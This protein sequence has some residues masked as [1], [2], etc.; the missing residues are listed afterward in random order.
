MI[1]AYILINTTH[2]R[3]RIV[4]KKLSQIE[5]IQEVEEVYGEYD[6]IA[7]I[8]VNNLD[9]LREVIYNKIRVI[10]GILR[11]ETLI[12]TSAS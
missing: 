5:G 4:S 8:V 12:S 2:D 6:I 1:L 10:D 9:E 7:K 3:T 11:T